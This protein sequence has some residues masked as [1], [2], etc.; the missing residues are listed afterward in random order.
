MDLQEPD[1]SRTEKPLPVEKPLPS[2]PVASFINELSP[3]KDSRSLLDASEKPLTISLGDKQ[4]AWPTLTPRS[5]SALASDMHMDAKTER[6]RQLTSSTMLLN[7]AANVTTAATGLSHLML[8]EPSA[9]ATESESSS[10]SPR[11]SASTSLHTA[12]ESMPE[13]AIS[14]RPH[15]A[16]TGHRD[17]GYPARHASLRQRISSG[18]IVSSHLGSKS[19]LTTFTDFT[20]DSGSATEDSRPHSPS[21]ASFSRPRPGSSSHARCLPSPSPS[22]ATPT[23]NVARDA[24]KAGRAQKTASRIPLPDVKKATLVDI[25]SRRSSG[26]STPKSERGPTFGTRRLDAPDTLKILDQGIKRRQ[27]TQLKR[28]N[29]NGSSTTATSSSTGV[30]H[31]GATPVL[32]DSRCSSPEGTCG[33]SSSDEEEVTTPA[34]KHFNLA[35]RGLPLDHSSKCYHDAAVKLFEGAVSALPRPPP[36]TSQF[37]GPLQTIPSQAILPFHTEDPAPP[38]AAHQRQPSD[39]AIMMKRFSNLHAA[40]ADHTAGLI[41]DRAA[42]PESTRYSLMDILSEYEREDVRLSREG[43][44]MLDDETRKNI[45]RTLSVLEGN[46]S[47]PKTQVDNETLLQMFGH[48]KRGLEKT[49][50]TASFVENAVAAQKYLT[51]PNSN[52]SQQNH[53]TGGVPPTGGSDKDK[54]EQLCAQDAAK[55]HLPPLEAVASKW[56]DSTS[57]DKVVSRT[58]MSPQNRHGGAKSSQP[59]P[60]KRTPPKP[61][62]SIGYPT[63]VPAKANALLGTGSSDAATPP[64]PVRPLSSPTLGKRKPGSVRAARETLD[65]VRGGFA[66]STTSAESKKTP[67]MP[68]PNTRAYSVADDGHRGRVPSAEKSR[69]KSDSATLPKVSEARKLTECVC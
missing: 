65:Q 17:D 67:K 5:T 64:A 11:S 59:Q 56:S 40:H 4:H 44:A 51:Q 2:R 55:N 1:A 31:H 42:A 46:G 66:R 16:D 68:T 13:D 37:T 19:K 20:K 22:N 26:T 35:D 15:D 39:F 69:T 10:K 29:T 32:D 23:S 38:V 58:G 49:P 54:S 62:Q 36:S 60:P 6:P 25:R 21:P 41:G 34:D 45:T 47:P 30:P 7:S 53:M 57:S 8:G 14:R 18:S 63:R 24:A 33:R 43:Y 9:S 3:S 52:A 48:L 50:K 61:P 28:T 27:L 12:K